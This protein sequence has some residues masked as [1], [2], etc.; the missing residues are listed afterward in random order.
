MTPVTT[1]PTKPPILY[2]TNTDLNAQP[3]K[4]PAII[5]VKRTMAA[6]QRRRNCSFTFLVT[7]SPILSVGFILTTSD[8]N[9]SVRLLGSSIENCRSNYTRSRHRGLV[10]APLIL[11]R[12]Q[13]GPINIF[14][15]AIHCSPF[16]ACKIRGATRA[17]LKSTHDAGCSF[18]TLMS[19]G[20]GQKD[21]LDQ[22]LSVPTG[23]S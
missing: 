12:I 10:S 21:D 2:P 23:D 22:S 13:S 11:P 8:R 17:A 19:S 3:T 7:T 14:S 5:N 15:K 6:R 20:V 9:E 4:Q 1:T 18:P 16:C